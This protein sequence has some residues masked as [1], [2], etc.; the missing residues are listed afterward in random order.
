MS[1]AQNFQKSSSLGAKKNNERCTP[2]MINLLLSYAHEKG[3]DWS[4]R[5]FRRKQACSEDRC[6][7]SALRYMLASKSQ[8]SVGMAFEHFQAVLMV[9]ALSVLALHCRRLVA[10]PPNLV[11]TAQCATVRFT[12]LSF[13]NGYRPGDAVY[14]AAVAATDKAGTR[15]RGSF[16]LLLDGCEVSTAALPLMLQTANVTA[17]DAGAGRAAETGGGQYVYQ[18]LTAPPDGVSGTLLDFNGVY[19]TTGASDD[20]EF[21]PAS[22]LVECRSQPGQ[23]FRIVAASG[24]CGWFPNGYPWKAGLGKGAATAMPKER[25]ARRKW[26]YTSASCKHSVHLQLVAGFAFGFGCMSATVWCAYL[27]RYDAVEVIPP[28][29][30]FMSAVF[31]AGLFRMAGSLLMF[32]IHERELWN[33]I[34]LMLCSVSLLW[35]EQWLFERLV[36]LAVFRI[37]GSLTM[38]DAVLFSDQDTMTRQILAW[39]VTVLMLFIGMSGVCCG[40]VPLVAQPL[41][42]GRLGLP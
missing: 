20:P 26:D 13:R 4:K 3:N 25:E 2:H 42:S 34:G 35:S 22:F 15:G 37:V 8:L 31:A 5:V 27:A 23:D 24:H 11:P 14:P 6:L 32:R 30:I 33:S 19:Y 16:G 38:E 10:F 7:L 39:S 9:V 40:G 12:V 1:S 28:V 21:D 17:T 41:V 29:L 18:Y 36:V